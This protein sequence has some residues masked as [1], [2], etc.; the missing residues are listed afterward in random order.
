MLGYDM[1]WMSLHVIIHLKDYAYLS[2]GNYVAQVRVVIL[3]H[4]SDALILFVCRAI[5]HSSSSQ[6]QPQM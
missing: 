5:F 3:I 2:Q 1:L 4:S 6:L